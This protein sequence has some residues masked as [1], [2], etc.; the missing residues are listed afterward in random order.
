MCNVTM[1]PRL[2][3]EVILSYPNPR[4]SPHAKLKSAHWYLLLD[5]FVH[6]ET[7]VETVY[8]H[9]CS[10]IPSSKHTCTCFEKWSEARLVLSSDIAAVGVKL[11]I[12]KISRLLTVN[13][14]I[15]SLIE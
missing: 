5:V 14:G 8:G 1:T 15:P 3:R 13:L 12:R 6:G 2:S 7:I 4:Q 10:W 9:I 11:G